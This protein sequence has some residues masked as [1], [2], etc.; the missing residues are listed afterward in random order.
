MVKREFIT[1]ERINRIA[2]FLRRSVMWL[3]KEDCGCCH[4]NLDDNFAIYVGWSGGFNVND[5]GL[6][7]SPSNRSTVHNLYMG[8][9]V[10]GY[11]ICASVKIR[12]DYDCADYEFTY[13]PH[14]N[15]EDGECWDNGGSLAPNGDYKVDAK[16]LMSTYVDMV[17]V[18]NHNKIKVD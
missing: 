3:K 9:W 11:A 8:D 1:K 18:L 16:D 13:Y 4:Y 17:N 2:D 15:D 10:C 7:T 12:N 14:F 5:K 6:I